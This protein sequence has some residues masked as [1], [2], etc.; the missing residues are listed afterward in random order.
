MSNTSGT[1]LSSDDESR[2]VATYERYLQ[3][4][5]VYCR[6][7]VS[8]DR[9]DDV[10]ADVFL[11]VWK[12][13]DQ[14]PPEDQALNWIYAIAYRSVLHQWRSGSRQRRLK[15]KLVQLGGVGVALPEEQIVQSHESRQVLDATSRLKA[16]DQ[17]I[18]RLSLWE[19]LS[20][21]EIASVLN[22][23]PEAARQRFSRALKS[24][25]KEFNRLDKES[26]PTPAAQEGGA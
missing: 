1:A 25:T 9:A 13:I 26:R 20:H 11:T 15:D 14:L 24:L 18:L 8:A 21:S 4:V 12:K 17:E 6:R 23:S 3:P 10:V 5:Y 7:R 2:F 16:V 22:L 19:E